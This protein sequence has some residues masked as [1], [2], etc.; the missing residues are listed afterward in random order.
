VQNITVDG[1]IDTKTKKKN[2]S[3]A[4]DRDE[5]RHEAISD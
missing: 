4:H 5:E 2:K 3:R 1:A